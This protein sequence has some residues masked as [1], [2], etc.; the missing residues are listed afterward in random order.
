MGCEAQLTLKWVFLGIFCSKADKTDPILGI[1]LG[2]IDTCRSVH[3]RLHCVCNHVCH[4]EWLKN[5]WPFAFWPSWPW[6]VGK[7]WNEMIL[8]QSVNS[9]EMYLW[10]KLGYHYR[11]EACTDN[12]RTSIYTD[13]PKTSKVAH[14]NEGFVIGLPSGFI[15]RSTHAR[16]HVCVWIFRLTPPWLTSRQTD[17]QIYPQTAFYQLLWVA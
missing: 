10:C 1:A 8:C 12:I 15:S 3:I 5:R 6:K 14:D 17:R 11:S 16:L 13:E 2:F 9:R 4:P 7:T